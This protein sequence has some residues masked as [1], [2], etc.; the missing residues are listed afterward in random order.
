MTFR[1]RLVALAFL[2]AAPLHAE[3]LPFG[4]FGEIPIHRPAGPPTQLVL[5]LAGTSGAE[6]VTKMAGSLASAGALVA[7]VDV[8][9]YLAAAGHNQAFCSYPSADLEGLG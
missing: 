9:R 5:L 8:P 7:I 1:L 6:A 4:R 3:S 2:L